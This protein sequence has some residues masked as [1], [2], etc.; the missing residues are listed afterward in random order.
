M[1]AHVKLIPFETALLERIVYSFDLGKFHTGLH[2][3]ISGGL[4]GIIYKCEILCSCAS[5]I[6]QHRSTQGFC[7]ESPYHLESRFLFVST[8]QNHQG[9]I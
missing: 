5:L 3:H 2:I 4:P 7:L 1:P 6:H 8:D 9:I